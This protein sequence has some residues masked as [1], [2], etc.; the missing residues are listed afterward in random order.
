MKF[1]LEDIFMKNNVI[2]TFVTS[3]AKVKGGWLVTHSLATG[4][5]RISSAMCFIPD[6][7]HEWSVEQ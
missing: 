5:K 3:R 7:N 4:N 6:E 1:D 2:S